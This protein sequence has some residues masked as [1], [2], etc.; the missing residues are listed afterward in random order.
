M[1]P[2]IV[3][4][5]GQTLNPGD[6]SW[7]P[8]ADLATLTVHEDTDVDLRLE[9]A[10]G[11]DVL[12]T[13]KVPLDGELLAE[14]PELRFVSALATGY[15]VVDVH[16]ARQ[17]GVIVSNVPAYAT[18]S[19]AQHT[20]ALLLELTNRVA[21]HD[22]AVRQGRWPEVGGFTFWTSP[23]TELAGKTLGIVGTGRIGRR[24]AEIAT[25]FGMNVIAYNRSSRPKALESVT[26]DDL[27][28]RAHVVSLHCPLTSDTRGLVDARR[29]AM[30]RSGAFL[31]NTSRGGLV[32]SNALA[33]ALGDNLAG[34]GLD[35][36]AEEP[37][38]ADHPL[39]ALPNV[40][41]TPHNAW[42]SREAR[43]RL[44]DVTV[45]NVAA[46]F[47]GSPQNVVS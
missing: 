6:L 18:D 3:V 8:L 14:L 19:V 21:E 22:S 47:A 38:A 16:A 27:F 17:R 10:R 23:L 34:A 2:S 12:L 44:L 13:N 46:F 1:S 45:A 20:F 30:M 4:L 37:I 42:T 28:R 36:V 24:V 35:V 32:D 31:I 15:D 33:E 29:L 25:A 9:R 5:D 41:V 39:L 40:V 7:A 43:Q 11:A 26:L